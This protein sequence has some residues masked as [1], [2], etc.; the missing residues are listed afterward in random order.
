MPLVVLHPEEL[1]EVQLVPL[2]RWPPTWCARAAFGWSGTLGTVTRSV[3]GSELRVKDNRWANT[4]QATVGQ[5][6]IKDWRAA[7]VRLPGHDFAVHA[8]I[9]RVNPTPD[10]CN[11]R[12]SGPRNRPSA[13]HFGRRDPRCGCGG[14]MPSA[15]FRGH[16]RRVYVERRHG[17]KS[18]CLPSV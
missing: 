7:T 1:R 5:Y 2:G 8:G 10:C 6:S 13:Q 12:R 18:V 16:A 11:A 15:S 3:Y 14:Q 4:A 17:H 9:A